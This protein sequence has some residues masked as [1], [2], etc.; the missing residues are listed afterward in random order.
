MRMCCTL[1]V[2]AIYPI[3]ALACY[4]PSLDHACEAYKSVPIIFTGTVTDLGYREANSNTGSYSQQIQFAVNE[5]FKG[6]S[7]G[8]I[9]VTRVHVQSSCASNA[10]EFVVAGRFLVWALPDEQGNPVISDCTPAR[11]FE[12]AAQF[13]SELRDLRAG[14]VQLTFSVEFTATAI[15]QTAPNRRS[16]RAIRPCH[17]QGRRC[18]CRQAIIATQQLQ[19]KKVISLCRWSEGVDIE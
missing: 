14:Q 1:L 13:I 12:D 16:W 6:G 5:S 19:T 11:R 3:S 17:L 7:A 10:P 18:W 4:C 2:I 9:T 15:F 8:S